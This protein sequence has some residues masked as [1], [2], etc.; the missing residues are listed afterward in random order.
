MYKILS[1]AWFLELLGVKE[2]L[3]V[4]LDVLLLFPCITAAGTS[5]Y[6]GKASYIFKKENIPYLYLKYTIQELFSIR[7]EKAVLLWLEWMG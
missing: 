3:Q 4:R 2:L 6:I 1:S 5:V 7:W